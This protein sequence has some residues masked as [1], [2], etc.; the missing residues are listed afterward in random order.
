M[1]TRVLE[2]DKISH[3][4]SMVAERGRTN[5]AN[6]H[7]HVKSRLK[8]SMAE[9]QYIQQFWLQLT[10]FHNKTNLFLI[11]TTDMRVWGDQKPESFFFFAYNTIKT[12]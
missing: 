6:V 5:R 10:S 12:D 7:T 2:P 3:T 4:Q 9:F 8:D 1:H 11:K